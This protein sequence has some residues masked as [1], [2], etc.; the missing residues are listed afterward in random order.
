MRPARTQI[1]K[2]F[3]VLLF[4]KE[5]LPS[6]LS[7]ADLVLPYRI[8]SLLWRQFEHGAAVLGPAVRCRPIE[9]AFGIGDQASNRGFPIRLVEGGANGLGPRRLA[10]GR[11]RQFDH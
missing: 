7:A 2:S 8:D 10:R 11:R 6:R 3:L 4:K 5:L 1:Y 9:V